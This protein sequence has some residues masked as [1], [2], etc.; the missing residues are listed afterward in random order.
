GRMRNSLRLWEGVLRTWA[1]E[2]LSALAGGRGKD[3]AL[4]YKNSIGFIQHTLFS[5]IDSNHIHKLKELCYVLRKNL[6]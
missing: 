6:P 4:E 1:M 3:L 5:L 2:V